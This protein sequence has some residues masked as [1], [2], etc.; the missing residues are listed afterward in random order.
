MRLP[1]TFWGLLTVGASALAAVPATDKA[2]IEFFEKNIRPIFAER[3]YKCH[4]SAE[5]KAKGGL[6]LD[7]REGWAKGGDTG[8]AIVPGKPDA[9]L[10]LKALSYTDDE[11]KMPPKKEG[12]KLPDAQIATLREWIAMGAPDPREGS[13]K[14]LNGLSSA[15]RAHWA[16]QPL[17]QSTLPPVKDK[18]WCQTV[19]DYFVLAKLEAAGLKPNPPADGEALL[20]RM[21]YDLIGLPPMLDE[22]NDFSREYEA[23]L[24]SDEEA[25]KAGK[26]PYQ[27]G[28]V[29]DRRRVMEKW[30]DRLLASKHYGERWGRHWLDS[31]RYSDT[32]GLV[33]M[34]GKYRYEDYR[35]MYAWT[36][37][38]YVIDAINRDKPYN[39]FL[40]E[41][42]A[43]DKLPDIQPSDPRL[44]ALGFLTVGKHFDNFDDVIDERIDTLTKA[45]MALTVSCAR[46]HDHKFDPI[47]TAD[48]YSLH[49]VFNSL[50][51]PYEKPEMPRTADAAQ[52]ADY[53]KELTELQTKNRQVIYD[54]LRERTTQFMDKAEGYLLV[55]TLPNR[56]PERYDMAAKYSIKPEIAEITGS[57]RLAPE[58]PIFGP[59]AQLSKLKRDETW[60]AK[61]AE[62][63]P[64]VL[65]DPKRPV[66]KMVAD[67][68][69]NLKPKTLDEVAKAYGTLFAQIRSHAA[70]YIAA[71]STPGATPPALIEPIVQLINA[72]Y[73]IPPANQMLTAEQQIG[74]LAENRRPAAWM[75]GITIQNRKDEGNNIDRLLFPAINELRLTH[76]GAPGCAMIVGDAPKPKDSYVYIRGD[77]GKKGPVVPRQFLE[78]FSGQ[79]RQPFK[80]GSG[81]YDLAVAIASP[82]NPLTARAAVNRI[83]LHHFGEGFVRSPDDL[84][85]MCEP[86]SHPE[87]FDWLSGW[88]MQSGWSLKQTHKLI[89]LSAAWQ[90]SADT[91][92]DHE[93]KDPGNRLLWRANLRRLDFESIRDSMLLLSGN[94]DR[95]LGGKPVNITDEPY[96][97][98]RSIYG[99]VDRLYLSDLMTQF[100]FANPEM[101]NTQRISTIVP[102]QALFFMNNPLGIEVARQVVNRSEVADAQDETAKIHAIYR[103]IFQRT[104]RKGE[105]DW[106]REFIAQSKVLAAKRPVTKVKQ[107]TA[108]KKDPAKDKYAAL[109]N[110]GEMV[111]RGPLNPWELYVQSLLC[112]NEFVYVN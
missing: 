67:A 27:N 48:Y 14:K 97:T 70:P 86:P 46:C 7:T 103:T 99:Y 55:I 2:S 82:Q 95:T 28:F 65:N 8:P 83:W 18:M 29:P 4:S 61:A 41:Q 6:T 52:R 63:L 3:C 90:Q 76:P 11:L 80:N 75:S 50:V 22:V 74:F 34:G 16:F 72:L 24:K 1:A 98:R 81:R 26:R 36:Y 58:H 77:R 106:A 13:G 104:P 38:D 78:I 111:K 21:Y 25:V 96:S 110:E 40:F 102:Q 20:R 33:S 37:R 53:E 45:T 57:I 112:T 68:L 19:V 47:P 60:P 31:A 10:L 85:N 42:I 107:A 51:E 69:R 101:A 91:H 54:I 89:L 79:N 12:G 66:N 32:R 30:I 92:P 5:G 108:S 9:S 64:K 44:A 43:A 59:F 62:L 23:A 71:Q 84:G 49:G 17:K 100:D 87:L 94:L 39:L 35:Y 73:W 15:A 88:F 109:R 105:V 56:S 93:I